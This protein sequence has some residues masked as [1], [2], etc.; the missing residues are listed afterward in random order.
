MEIKRYGIIYKIENTINGKCYIG[1]TTRSFNKRYDCKGVGIERVYKYYK[2]RKGNNFGCI[3]ELVNDIEKYG[4][5]S[6]IVEEELD[7]AYSKESLDELEK[8]YIKEFNCVGNG[9]NSEHGGRNASPSSE[10]RKKLSESHKGKTHSEET[11]KKIRENHPDFSGEN[12][13]MYG[14][15]HSEET[16]NKMREN[17]PFVKKVVCLND[18]NIFNTVSECARYYKKGKATITRICTNKSQ[19]RDGVRFMYY[20]EYIISSYVI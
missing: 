4:L 20:D 12:H 14:K 8:K 1:Q 5:D 3:E 17:N 7:I 10:T 9:Y 18:G 11:R 19:T 6:F 13:P 16:R 15:T 2:K